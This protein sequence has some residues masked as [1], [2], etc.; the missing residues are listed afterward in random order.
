MERDARRTRSSEGGRSHRSVVGSKDED[1]AKHHRRHHGLGH[2]QG[3]VWLQHTF[4]GSFDSPSREQG[5]VDES[6]PRTSMRCTPSRAPPL[7]PAPTHCA[8][9]GQVCLCACFRGPPSFV[10]M[11][12]LISCVM[13]FPES[14]HCRFRGLAGRREGIPPLQRQRKTMSPAPACVTSQSIRHS[15]RYENSRTAHDMELL[16]T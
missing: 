7:K 1:E 9:R 6:R 13:V 12:S 16:S 4:V 2:R 15:Q 5:T 8:S 10:L 3:A 14:I 11:S